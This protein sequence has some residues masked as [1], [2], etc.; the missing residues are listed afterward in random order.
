VSARAIWIIG[1]GGA[2]AILAALNFLGPET[3][4]GGVEPVSRPPP[5]SERAQSGGGIAAPQAEDTSPQ[6]NGDVDA[7]V[8]LRADASTESNAAAPLLPNQPAATPMGDVLAARGMPAPPELLETERT[9]AAEARDPYWSTAAESH[10]LARVAE[11]PALALGSLEVEC[12]QT[13][14]RLQFVA[15]RTIPESPPSA[16]Q[17]AQLRAG[18]QVPGIAELVRETG[19][20]GRWVF[21]FR[22]VSMAYLERG[23][24]PDTPAAAR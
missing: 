6:P 4:S 24:A 10:I 11:I 9:F 16:E 2:L 21:G 1:L 17:L 13:L 22:P 3:G 7:G 23:E 15:P 12:R 14:C 8:T 18:P 20:K 5:A 19:L